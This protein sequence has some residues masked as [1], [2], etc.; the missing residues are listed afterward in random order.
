MGG[1]E[2]DVQLPDGTLIQ[3]VPDGTTKLQLLA[4]LQKNKHPAAEAL[5]REM[6]GTMAAE[7]ST[8]MEKFNAGVGLGFQNIGRGAKQLIGMDTDKSTA[9]ADK[10]LLNTGSGLSGNIIGNVAAFAPLSMVPGANTIAGAG[11]IGA[12]MG[13]LQPTE[14]TGERLKNM[15][16][17]GVLGTGGQG[18]AAHPVEVME[19]AKNLL[20]RPFKGAK[21]LV[22]PL[23]EQGRN[24]ILARTLSNATNNRQDVV[25]N[26]RNAQ[27]L[28]PGSSPTAAEVGDSGGLAALQ[29]SA[30]AVDPEAYATRAAQQNEA[31]SKSL[32]DMAGTQGEREFTA[33][34]R[35]ATASDL[36]KQA[37][38][39]GIDLTKMSPARRGEITKLLRTP[40]L[41]N[42][43]GE[44]RVLSQNEMTNVKN[45]AGSVQGLDYVKRAL[46]D[47][48]KKATGN[49]QRVL[50]GLKDRLLTTI[51]TLSP[52]YAAARKVYA[53]MSKP[54][55]QMDIAQHIADKSI[56]PLTG[57]IK[58]EMYARALSDNTAASVSGMR[59]ATLENTMTPEQLG[60]LGNIREDLARSVKARDMGRGSGSDTTQK[61]A[62]SNLMQQSGLP[63]GVLNM[64]GMPRVANWIYSA[65]DEQMRNALSKILLDPQ[66]TARIMS[67]TKPTLPMLRTPPNQ[68][69]IPLAARALLPAAISQ[70]SQ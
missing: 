69:R 28:V 66:E 60:A 63:M 23:Y 68:S 37:Y 17:G 39:L 24:Q 40:A 38:D 35:A 25:K 57:A 62:M 13:A 43:V 4:K 26:L 70:E 42:A 1:I 20:T 54:I 51:D 18:V 64:P 7:G 58:P 22:E 16:V 52:E 32:L 30:S 49:E 19:G 45:P 6:A 50:V 29:R 44:A 8:G 15:F 5:G 56:S 34:N 2:I 55:T 41:Q 10:A 59:N 47:Q 36:Y 65:S 53:D 48:I 11:S 46:D 3:G 31:R 27:T 33:A 61:L 67:M 9:E 14:A 12:T 21:A